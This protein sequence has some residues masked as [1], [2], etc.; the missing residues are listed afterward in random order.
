M[1]VFPARG[2]LLDKTVS[3][4]NPCRSTRVS[5]EYES[6][7]F[8]CSRGAHLCTWRPVPIEAPGH[9]LL[10]QQWLVQNHSSTQM[11]KCILC[12]LMQA[13]VWPY[14]PTI[15]GNYDCVFCW[16]E[17]G[18]AQLVFLMEPAPVRFTILW[19]VRTMRPLYCQVFTT[20]LAVSTLTICGHQG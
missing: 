6:S 12:S 17:E 1:R 2:V 7:H 20:C 10:V 9:C 5:L 15:K 8:L 11:P 4:C 18:K 3:Q 16:T 19:V 13:T 14:R